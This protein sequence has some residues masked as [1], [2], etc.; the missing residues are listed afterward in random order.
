MATVSALMSENS[1]DLKCRSLTTS[2]LSVPQ[3]DRP[4]ELFSSGSQAA[5][6]IVLGDPTNPPDYSQWQVL[7]TLNRVPDCH[8]LYSVHLSISN[9]N[10][11]SAGVA[12]LSLRATDKFGQELGLE[13][14]KLTVDI[15]ESRC[16]ELNL[17][18][19]YKTAVKEVNL[20]GLS[21]VSDISVNADWK[22]MRG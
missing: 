20:L 17:V 11:S 21:D 22:I 3:L 8:E 14:K 19:P 1:Y 13:E 7:Q 2:Q 10:S 9:N 16:V 5:D 4:F 12:C 15:G 6:I 18:L